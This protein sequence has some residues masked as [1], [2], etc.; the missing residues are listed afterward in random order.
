M[1]LSVEAKIS[2]GF[3]L[4]LLILAVIA[5]VSYQSVTRQTNDAEW[6][7][8]THQVLHESEVMLSIM[9][10]V[11]T[12]QRGYVIAGADSF[13]EPYQKASV[14]AGEQ[15]RRLREL[16]ADNPTQQARLDPLE[17][18]VNERLAVSRLTV[19]TRSE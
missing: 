3:G 18:L 15:L 6:V 2:L 16:T 19:E 4:G 13:L 7:K 8:H 10:D 11:E 5:L 1:S 9:V 12:G 17:T 14:K